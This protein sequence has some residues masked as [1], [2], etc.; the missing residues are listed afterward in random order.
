MDET[1]LE[2]YTSIFEVD[3]KPIISPTSFTYGLKD[4][5]KST[6]GMTSDSL[7]H[8][9]RAA[10][11]RKIS[12]TWNDVTLENAHA[13]LSAFSPVYV[14][15]RYFDTLDFKLETKTF[16]VGDISAPYKVW[17]VR[18]KKFNSISFEIEER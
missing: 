4:V 9:I 12:L 11:K 3:G 8:K 16:M 10:Q 2:N 6:S 5:K 15:I 14:E 17:T 13:I 1:N 7:N 18:N